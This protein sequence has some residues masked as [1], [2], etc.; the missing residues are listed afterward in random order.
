MFSWQ[1]ISRWR[2]AA[3]L[4][5]FFAVS[6]KENN[7]NPAKE[8]FPRAK[9]TVAEACDALLRDV[10]RKDSALGK[11][12]VARDLDFDE[13]LSV[14]GVAGYFS[15]NLTKLSFRLYPPRIEGNEKTG[16]WLEGRFF[17]SDNG[18]LRAEV[19]D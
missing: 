14:G 16:P 13:E 1:S 8:R 15:M 4:F 3:I 2:G 7:M 11:R 9:P 12:L 10:I 6:C 5:L 18:D 17:F 19:M